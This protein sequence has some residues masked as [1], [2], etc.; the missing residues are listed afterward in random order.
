MVATIRRS[1]DGPAFAHSRT[2]ICIREGDNPQSL[3]CA[4]DLN[5]P[6]VSRVRSPNDRAVLANHGAGVG[7]H[8]G[9]AAKIVPLR[10]RI[11]PVPT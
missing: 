1:D 10:K 9:S 2:V 11:L 5:C 6:A 8:K 4:A 3:C 7:V